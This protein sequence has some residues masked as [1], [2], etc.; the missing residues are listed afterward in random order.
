M[1]LLLQMLKHVQISPLR[2]RS[3][4]V[5]LRSSSNASSCASSMCGSPE[6]PTDMQRTPSRASSYSSLNEQ[7]PQVSAFELTSLPLAETNAGLASF[8]PQTTIKVYTN[9]LKIDIE[10]KTLGI[11][12][13]TTSKE[14]IA[15]LLRR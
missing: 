14:V 15:Q 13:D 11:Q 9:C 10:Y 3:D 12:W 7:P 1:L 6:P 8:P 2:N 4:S 5:S